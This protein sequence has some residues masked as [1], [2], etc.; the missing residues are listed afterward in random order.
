MSINPPVERQDLAT[1]CLR[2]HWGGSLILPLPFL[3]AFLPAAKKRRAASCCEEEEYPERNRHRKAFQSPALSL[4]VVSV[5]LVA[6]DAEVFTSTPAPFRVFSGLTQQSE[7][8]ADWPPAWEE[9]R[10]FQRDVIVAFL[11][12]NSRPWAAES[13]EERQSPSASGRDKTGKDEDAF[14]RVQT[15]DC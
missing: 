11:P 3:P 1:F 14:L 2:H 15:M 12:T 13:Q 9:A 6:G 7:Q 10:D 5:Q 4:A 8:T